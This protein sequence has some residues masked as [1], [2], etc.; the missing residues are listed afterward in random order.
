VHQNVFVAAASAGG[1]IQC[2]T[3][4]RDV[5]VSV[6]AALSQRKHQRH[7]QIHYEQLLW[8]ACFSVVSA[9]FLL[10]LSLEAERF[11]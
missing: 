11:D 5:S 2:E 10:Y 7:G 1:D 6:N 8:L 3:D 9:V 4:G